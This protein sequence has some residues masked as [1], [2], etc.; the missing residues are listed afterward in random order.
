MWEE[1]DLIVAANKQI[2]I[3]SKMEA[4]ISQLGVSH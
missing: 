2:I 3:N 1:V 4:E